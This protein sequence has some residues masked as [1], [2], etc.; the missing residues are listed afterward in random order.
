M[1]EVV[2]SAAYAYNSASFLSDG[3]RPGDVD[4]WRRL[5]L[6]LRDQEL[7]RLE[8]QRV[9][10]RQ[11]LAAE[12]EYVSRRF[13]KLYK[14]PDW[15]R[16]SPDFVNIAVAGNS[17]AGKSS[18]INAIRGLRA[19]DPG[20]AKVGVNETTMK[21]DAY[22]CKQLPG[23]WIWDLPGAGTELFPREDYIETIGLRHFDM[24]IVISSQRF[25][26]TEVAISAELRRLR[27][28]HFMV[29]TKVDIDVANNLNDMGVPPEE[30]LNILREEM[31]RLG[32]ERP[33]LVSSRQREKFDMNLLVQGGLL[34]ALRRL[35]III[36][37]ETTAKS[38][39]GP[40]SGPAAAG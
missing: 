32:V 12:R 21:P 29:R 13:D 8:D 3:V 40:P 16:K 18:F 24:V 14:P 28:G 33:F 10:N 30:T 11:L 4:G 34:P 19:S 9:Q 17:G 5:E 6:E 7:R 39:S 35:G 36:V 1:G 38:P 23:V 2:S 27:I 25:T 26:E 37:P 31:K 15:L 20:A 22:E